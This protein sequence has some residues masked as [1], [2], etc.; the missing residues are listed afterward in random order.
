MIRLLH[1]AHCS[2][3]R[4][5]LALL[6][7]HAANLDVVDYLNTPLSLAELQALR[8]LLKV[9]A[10]AL[11]RSGEAIYETLGL[12]DEQLGDDAL[13]GAIAEHPILL[14]RPI[15]LNGVRAVIARPPELALTV[16]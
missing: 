3:S 15:A 10:R 16:L 1:N 5:A 8:A 14:Q 7:P 4:E 12:A 6:S 9:P 2:K 11:L 13:L